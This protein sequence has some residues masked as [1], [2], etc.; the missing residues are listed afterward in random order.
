MEIILYLQN[1][2]LQFTE[3]LVANYIN[4]LIILIGITGTLGLL[5]K[6]SKQNPFFKITYYF[7]SILILFY[8]LWKLF[9]CLVKFNN[10]TNLF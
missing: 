9:I 7:I 8:L 3:Y 1:T 10:M 6:L 2:I 5:K 4:G